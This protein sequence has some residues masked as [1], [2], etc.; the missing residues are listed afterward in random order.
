MTPDR[1]GP[2]RPRSEPGRAKP[3]IGVVAIGGGHGLAVTLQA[4]ATYAGTLT[5]VVSVADDGGSSGRLRATTGLPAMGDIRRCLS[6]MAEPAAL[7]QMFEHRF[8]ADLAGHALG[9]LVIAAL[10]QRVGFRAAIDE[11]ARLLR[12]PARVLPATEAPVDLVAITGAGVVHG[13]VAVQHSTGIE[14]VHLDPAD[15][16]ADEEA[17][18]AIAAADQVVIGPGS[19]YTSVLAALAVPGIRDAVAAT[20]AQVVYVCNLRPQVP[21]TDGY[22]AARH[23][24]ALRAHGV[25]PDVVVDDSGL[26]VDDGR[27]HDPK[28]LGPVLARLLGPAD[29]PE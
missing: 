8:D 29:S 16:A 1:G 21:E 23:T 10:A 15:P 27:A 5:A 18:G 12:V 28:L 20:A 26:A 24:E 11:L 2:P 22:T 3:P 19:L 4:A 9:N 17:V 13:Q 14:R 6:T 7:G 25:T